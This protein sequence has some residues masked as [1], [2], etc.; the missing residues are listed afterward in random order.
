M[1][2]RGQAARRQRRCFA[3]AR[4]HIAL[5]G[6]PAQFR[7][8]ARCRI[9]VSERLGLLS[10]KCDIAKHHWLDSGEGGADDI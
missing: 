8:V 4:R 10:I 1:L 6:A 5:G 9:D 2:G 3:T 7:C